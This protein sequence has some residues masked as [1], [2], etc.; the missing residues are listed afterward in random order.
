MRRLRRVTP[1]RL[2]VALLIAIAVF[3]L[4]GIN[5]VL[6]DSPSSHWNLDS[7]WTDGY[8]LAY[9]T[10]FSA[11]LLWGAGTCALIAGRRRIFG[12]RGSWYLL[13]LLLVGMGFD[14]L[15][16][17]HERLESATGVDWQTLY[18]PIAIACGVAWL[19][20]TLSMRRVKPARALMILGAAAWLVAQILEATQW[21]GDRE[22][23]SYAIQMVIEETLEM[24]G[25][26]LFLVAIY[27]VLFVSASGMA[28]GVARAR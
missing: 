15:L 27:W 19:F 8:G 7:D 26:T 1:Q 24:T 4:A 11:A 6:T 28:V 2:L 12:R 9:P 22:V 23:S 10:L 18:A 16:A 5:V 20:I 3:S 17:T 21:D 13:G 14:E 25:S